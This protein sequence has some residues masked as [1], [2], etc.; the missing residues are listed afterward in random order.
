M[1][2]WEEAQ[3]KTQ[4]PLE[5]LWLSA[6]LKTPHRHSAELEEVARE[7]EVLTSLLRLLPMRPSHR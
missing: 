1:S 6:G 4:D 7:R 3:L 5:G 2:Q